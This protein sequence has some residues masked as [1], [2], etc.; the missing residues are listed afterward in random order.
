MKLRSIVSLGIF[1]CGAVL[2]AYLGLQLLGPASGQAWPT[3]QDNPLPETIYLE[4]RLIAVN[5]PLPASWTL[6]EELYPP[7]VW[8]LQ[9]LPETEILTNGQQPIE[10]RWATVDAVKS[11]GVLKATRIAVS[12]HPRPVRI[13]GRLKLVGPSNAGQWV[14]EHYPFKVNEETLMIT[15]GLVAER[16]TYARAELLKLPDGRLARSVELLVPAGQPGPALELADW[17][18]KID[19]ATGRWQVG[20]RTVLVDEST[21]V[22]GPVAVGSLVRVHGNL[23]EGDVL[24]QLIEVLPKEDGV[25]IQG[26]ING[27]GESEWLVDNITV[28]LDEDTVRRGPPPRQGMWA[29]VGGAQIDAHT[30]RATYVWV[31]PAGPG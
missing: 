13:E 22:Q 30:V 6:D 8:D 31:D 17:L 16:G 27:V 7:Q 23:L 18:V 12:P 10:G 21:Q 26:V 20:N 24:A 5:Y 4:G 2:G 1:T 11:E 19:E 9:V 14:L 28:L 15:N 29:Q 25:V 3:A